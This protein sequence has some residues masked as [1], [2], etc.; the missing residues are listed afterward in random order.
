VGVNSGTDALFLALKALGIGAGDEVI[1]VSNTAVPTVSA[2]CA[3]GATARFVDIEPGTY[4]MD[5]SL[6][7]AALTER[8]RCIIAVHLFGQCVDMTALDALARQYGLSVIEDCAQAHGAR[9]QGRLAGSM[10]ELSAFSFY[11]TKI[12]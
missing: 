1:T 4:L 11:P 9:Q 7:E 8:T 5:C 6:L 10:S 12:L 3:T 2:I